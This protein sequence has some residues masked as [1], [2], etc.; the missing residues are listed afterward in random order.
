MGSNSTDGVLGGMTPFLAGVAAMFASMYSTQAILPDLGK[1]FHVS[2][3][4]SGLTISVVI[5]ALAIGSWIWGPLSDRIGRRRSLV[6]SSTALIVPTAFLSFSPNFE[7]LLLLRTAQGLCM[8]GLLTV[9]VP[10]VTETYAPRLGGK[11]MGLYTSALIAGSVTGRVGV[12][13]VTSVAGWRTALALLA[14]M[15][16]AAAVMMAR[17]LPPEPSRPAP[18]GQRSQGRKILT[19]LHNRNL[20]AATIGGS[21]LMFGFMG[22]CSY[23]PYRLE[24]PP[25]S[26]SHA[27]TS[28]IFGFWILGLLTPSAGRLAYRFGWRKM[29]LVTMATCA[30]GG[31]LTLIPWLPAVAAGFGLMTVSNFAAVTTVQIG[32]G[33]SVDRDHGTATAIYYSVYYSVGALGAYLP[34]ILWQD[35]GWR[36]VIAGSL[37]VYVVGAA[38]LVLLAG[39]VWRRLSPE[40]LTI[41]E[42]GITL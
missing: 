21:A 31:A 22:V 10:Y 1:A 18:T 26:L 35:F 27:A 14:I 9:G 28:A 39:R 30:L 37:G 29:A 33:L 16:T 41:D 40:E 24:H 25:F 19:L 34:G 17:T 5:F 38:A 2:P 6:Y 15:P 42:A 13:L 3:S 32:V 36:G 8:P 7:T 4:R 23:I 20:V 12:A 11:A